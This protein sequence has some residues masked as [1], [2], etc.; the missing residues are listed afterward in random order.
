[1]QVKGEWKDALHCCEDA[2]ALQPGGEDASLRMGMLYYERNIG[3]EDKY[4]AVVSGRTLNYPANCRPW[5]RSSLP[6]P[7]RTEI[8]PRVQKSPTMDSNPYI[9]ALSILRHALGLA[10]PG[11][12][13]SVGILP[14]RYGSW[15]CCRVCFQMHC[16]RVQP[17]KRPGAI[18]D[19]SSRAWNRTTRQR[20]AWM[21][22]IDCC[23]HSL[24]CLSV[25]FRTACEASSD[26]DVDLGG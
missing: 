15:S 21:R 10:P 18:K 7:S 26:C 3:L 12:R 9:T 25:K 17:W 13:G 8:A 14:Q 19:S 4:F 1:L 23:S 5:R 24:H 16:G 11:S 20:N 22:P 2:L 6:V